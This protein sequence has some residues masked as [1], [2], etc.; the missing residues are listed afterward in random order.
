[1]KTN[2][3]MNFRNRVEDW[4]GTTL[5]LLKLQTWFL[6]FRDVAFLESLATWCNRPPSLDVKPLLPS[7]YTFFHVV[8]MNTFCEVVSDHARMAVLTKMSTL[9]T[10]VPL[11]EMKKSVVYY[12]TGLFIYRMAIRHDS[13][14]ALLAQTIQPLI[15]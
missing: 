7:A 6:K 2:K 10:A 9:E 11:V 4:Y 13:K 12:I 3:P 14:V 5:T 8:F 15:T 1:M